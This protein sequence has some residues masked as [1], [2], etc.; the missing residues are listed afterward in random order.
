MSD[1]LS[2]TDFLNP[3]SRLHLSH[4]EDYREG[5]IGKAIALYEEESRL[6]VA[7]VVLIGCGEQEVKAPSYSAGDL[8]RSQF[9]L[10]TTGIRI[11]A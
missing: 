7:D 3:V 10:C 6:D 9:M 8:I 11:F 1:V 4:D 2:I 5:Q